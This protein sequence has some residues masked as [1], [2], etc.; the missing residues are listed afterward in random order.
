MSVVRGK[1]HDYVV[2]DLSTARTDEPLQVAGDTIT[3][4]S[5]DG[6]L[7]AKVNDTNEPAIA[8]HAIRYIDFRPSSFR[9]IYLTNTAQAGKSAVL[10]IG[11]EASFLIEPTRSGVVGILN[12]AEARINPATEET[13]ATRA[14]EATLKTLRW[15]RDVSPSWVHGDEVTAPP[16][17]TALVSK[18]VGTG[19][20][21]YI[22]GFFISA[23]EANDFKINWTSGGAAESIRI[24]FS[25]KGAIQYVDFAALNEGLPADGGTS[26][27]ITN[28][29][30]GGTGIVYQARILYV[31]V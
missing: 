30:A 4:Q 17:G 9:R 13:L 25:S 3:V 11:K 22:Y 23:G 6:E 16:A 14:S 18:T 5:I 24:P 7:Y 1:L 19:K 21:G 2:I 15:G 28:V 12:A 10:R 8:L 26:I 29:N 27:T 20:S 31:E